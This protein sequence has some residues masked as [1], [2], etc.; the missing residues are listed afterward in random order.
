MNTNEVKKLS[1]IKH[2]EGIDVSL[3]ISLAEYGIAW[4]TT[5]LD[6]ELSDEVDLI[7]GYPGSYEDGYNHFYYTTFSR[8]DYEDLFDDNW[9]DVEE[10]AKTSGISV[11]E[12]RSDFPYGIY[13]FISYYGEQNILGS[14]PMWESAY[15]TIDWDN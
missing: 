9:C 5:A 4:D 6:E 10:V 1:D 11:E 12:L 15:F 13:S 14:Y 2:Y 3:D 8:S 7:V